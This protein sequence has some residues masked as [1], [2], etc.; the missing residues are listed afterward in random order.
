MDAG[1]GTKGNPKKVKGRDIKTGRN[2]RIACQL[3]GVGLRGSKGRI[4]FKTERRKLGRPLGHLFSTGAFC[5][6][7]PLVSVM[8]IGPKEEDLYCMFRLFHH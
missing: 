5:Q 2:E 7:S 4:I 3:E 1:G 8:G 6:L